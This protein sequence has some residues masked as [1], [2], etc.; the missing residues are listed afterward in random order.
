MWWKRDFPKLSAARFQERL[1]VQRE[2]FD[3]IC[4]KLSPVLRGKR[5][6]FRKP[7]SVKKKVAV[8]L[9]RLAS[10]SELRVLGDVFGIGTSSAHK[11]FSEFLQAFV[12]EF[13]SE[14]SWPTSSKELQVIER[15]LRLLWDYDHC[16]GAIDGCHIAVSP[17]EYDAV[18]FYNHKSFYSKNLLAVCDANYLFTYV[19][20]GTPGRAHDAFIFSNSQLHS[21][22]QEQSELLSSL[23]IL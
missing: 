14:I 19:N 20:I 4:K 11:Y 16:I 15:D 7:I 12:K 17:A 9:Y 10:C 5:S 18:D 13:R 21:C 2:T 8:G 22:L 23:K 3:H 1:R 6:N